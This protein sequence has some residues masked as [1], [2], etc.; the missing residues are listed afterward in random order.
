VGNEEG[1]GGENVQNEVEK[2]QKNDMKRKRD[3]K[4]ERE[5]EISLVLFSMHALRRSGA[6]NNR[7]RAVR[8]V[9]SSYHYL[10]PL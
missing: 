6:E 5:V 4:Q 9:Y 8:P 1:A 2:Q 10:P 7:S 3:V